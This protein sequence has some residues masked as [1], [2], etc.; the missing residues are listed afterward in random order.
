MQRLDTLVALLG[1]A[2]GGGEAICS[3]S[4]LI[5]APLPSSNNSRDGVVQLLAQ[6]PTL[7][8]LGDAGGERAC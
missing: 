1:G 3:E 6:N 5:S 2:S 8:A 4:G 7:L